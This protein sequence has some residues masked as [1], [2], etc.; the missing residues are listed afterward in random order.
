MWTYILVEQVIMNL[1]W[2]EENGDYWAA[3]RVECY[4]LESNAPF[5]T[6]EHF[7]VIHRKDWNNFD[8]YLMNLQTENLLSLDELIKNSNLNI[9][10]FKHEK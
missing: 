5:S 6:H 10:K 9:V 4:D 7:V 3:G 2:I 1:D 8:D